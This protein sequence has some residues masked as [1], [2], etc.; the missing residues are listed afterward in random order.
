M[1]GIFDPVFEHK[2]CSILDS[3]M[4]SGKRV[5]YSVPLIEVNGIRRPEFFAIQ[6]CDAHNHAML[7]RA[8]REISTP[9]CETKII[10]DKNVEFLDDWEFYG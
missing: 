6:F 8:I 2:V 9:D 7:R 5:Y 4:L 1:P 3:I 10:T